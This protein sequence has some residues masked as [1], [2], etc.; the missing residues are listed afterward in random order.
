MYR[1]VKGVDILLLEYIFTDG[2]EM[3]DLERI[4]RLVDPRDG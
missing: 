1:R 2:C 3:D 4:G